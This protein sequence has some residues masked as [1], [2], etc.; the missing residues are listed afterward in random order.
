[1]NEKSVRID[2]LIL[3]AALGERLELYR[4][5][6]KSNTIQAAIKRLL[7]SHLSEAEHYRRLIA[8]RKTEEG[9]P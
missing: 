5:L 7:D 2:N 4:V 9:K 8:E 6:S 1:M 3:S